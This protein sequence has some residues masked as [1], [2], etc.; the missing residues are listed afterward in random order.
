MPK[1]NVKDCKQCGGSF[2]G[3]PSRRYCSDACKYRYK[4]PPRDG[5]KIKYGRTCV[6]CG[7]VYDGQ[8]HKYCS[9][10]CFAKSCVRRR[11]GDKSYLREMVMEA[12][13]KPCMDC[14]GEYPTYVMDL[15]HRDPAEK[16][17]TVS[18]QHKNVG[19]ELLQAEIDKCD[20]ICSNCHRIRHHG[21]N[22]NG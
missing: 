10:A 1:T 7:S 22:E 8:R 5:G 19:T 3:H 4:Y 14:K 13:S 20:V 2:R 21:S 11:N 6:E 17:F 16:S 9:D 18:S 12:K 15:H